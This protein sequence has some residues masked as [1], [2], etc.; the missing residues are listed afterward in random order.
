MPAST[1]ADCIVIIRG[2]VESHHTSKAVR[3]LYR[4]AVL[5]QSTMLSRTDPVVALLAQST[6]LARTDSVVALLAQ[7]TKRARTDSG[8]ISACLSMSIAELKG[9]VRVF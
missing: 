3:S 7:S 4:P 6:T 2:C 1:L 9:F 5:A 8:A